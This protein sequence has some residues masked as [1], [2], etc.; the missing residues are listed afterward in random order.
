E[1][2]VMRR[3][4]Q[5]PFGPINVVDI[6]QFDN[7]PQRVQDGLAPI[8]NLDFGVVA[9]NPNGN[10]LAVAEDFKTAYAQQFNLQLQQALPGDMVGKVGYVGNLGRRLDNT[11][12]YNQ[13]FPGPGAP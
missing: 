7:D 4:R 10:M 13:P 3:H 11:F 1:A 6:N 2:V 12:N 8:P 5:L 9:E